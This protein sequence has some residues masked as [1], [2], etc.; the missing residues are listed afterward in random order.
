MLDRPCEDAK[1]QAV[2]MRIA[3]TSMLSPRLER[4]GRIVNDRIGGGETRRNSTLEPSSLLSVTAPL[5][6]VTPLR[7]VCRGVICKVV[8]RYANVNPAGATGIDACSRRCGAR[9]ELVEVR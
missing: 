9:P 2:Y 5:V 6:I 8:V 4:I 7:N 1:P 3:A